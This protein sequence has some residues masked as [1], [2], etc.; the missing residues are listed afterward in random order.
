MKNLFAKEFVI[1]KA[2]TWNGETFTVNDLDKMVANFDSNEPPHIIIGHSSDYKGHTRIPSFGRILGGL[3]RVGNDLVAYG[4]EFSEKLAEWIKEGYYNQRSVEMSIT[5]DRILALGMLGATPPG[6]KGMPAMDEALDEVLAY[7]DTPK[8]R[9]SV[10]FSEGEIEITSLEEAERLAL[11]D[12]FECVAQCVAEYLKKTEELLSMKAE[13]AMLYDAVWNLQ[14]ELM[15]ELNLHDQFM[16][17]MEQMT[18]ESEATG[19][20]KE[21]ISKKIKSLITKRKENIVDAKKEKEYQDEIDKLKT[22]L[23]VFSDANAKAEADRLDA[24][25]KTKEAEAKAKDDLLTAEIKTFCDTAVKENRMIP[26]MR[27]D[28]EHPGDE[29]IMF[30]LGKTSPEALKSFQ[31]K[32]STPIVPLGE[33]KK[34]QSQEQTDKRPLVIQRAELYVKNH[35]KQF[36]GLSAEKAIQRAIYLQ[37]IGEIKFEDK[38]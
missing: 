31:Q 26:A 12:T 15:G 23:K 10:E 33:E 11:K 27:G 24:E 9:K 7:S 34:M 20:W 3:K 17:K 29:A 21:F 4:V 22:E 30:T 19:G 13:P 38:K 36:S 18:E 25:A 5:N 6:V 32:Y 1:F 37:S 16:D 8:K 35:P 14:S 28:A 2:G